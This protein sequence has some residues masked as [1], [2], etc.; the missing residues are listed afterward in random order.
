MVEFWPH[1][2][3]AGRFKSSR[4][5]GIFLIFKTYLC[6]LPIGNKLQLGKQTLIVEGKI[7]QPLKIRIFDVALAQNH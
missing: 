3:E 7:H 2:P 5:G 4:G 6:K 1:K